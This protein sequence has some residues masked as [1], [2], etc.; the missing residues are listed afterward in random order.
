MDHLEGVLFID[1]ISRL[2]RDRIIRKLKK[3]Q[4]LTAFA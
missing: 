4:R 3:E 1:R 2:K